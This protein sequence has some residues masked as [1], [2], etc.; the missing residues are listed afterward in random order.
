MDDDGEIVDATFLAAYSTV[1]L[2]FAVEYAMTM[3]QD[4]EPLI[5]HLRGVNIEYPNGMTEKQADRLMRYADYLLEQPR[6]DH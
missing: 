5:L 3:L 4:G 6:L 2:V 1:D